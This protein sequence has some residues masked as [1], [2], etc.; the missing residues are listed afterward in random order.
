MYIISIR[1]KVFLINYHL[2]DNHFPDIYYIIYVNETLKWLS[3]L[4]YAV[5]GD[6]S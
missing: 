4:A 5:L 3:N 2:I 6:I 1:F